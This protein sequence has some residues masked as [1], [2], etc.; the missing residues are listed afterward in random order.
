M[1]TPCTVAIYSSRIQTHTIRRKPI[2]TIP[3][4]YGILDLHFSPHHQD[5]FCTANST[6]SLSLFSTIQREH[7]DQ[8]PEVSVNLLGFYELFP[9]NTL[10]LACQWHPRH[11]ELIGVSL[12]NGN[13]VIVHVR[14][15]GSQSIELGDVKICASHELE[16]WTLAFTAFSSGDESENGILSGGD[17]SF[18][19]YVEE[20]SLK[21]SHPDQA[22]FHWKNRRIH[23]AGVTAIL[24]LASTLVLTGS[25]DD[26]V[27]LLNIPT[28]PKTLPRTLAEENID[29][30]VWR[31]KVIKPWSEI[32]NPETRR[33]KDADRDDFERL[34]LDICV[35][36]SCM[37]AGVR[38]LRV[39][40]SRS[41][42]ND[43]Q[44]SWTISVVARFEEHQSMNYGS[45][46]IFL[47]KESG[48]VD[49]KQDLYIVSTSFYDK[50]VCLTHVPSDIFTE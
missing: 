14:G 12:S 6:R 41:L 20:P 25:Y 3:T 11:P 29:G 44:S 2:L 16:A 31:L 42:V 9:E 46:F 32:Y 10:A 39:K 33:E 8:D 36:A 21:D 50:L 7:H 27:R 13:V 4:D 49:E 28:K 30:G 1:K 48:K 15:L 45:E 26:H 17:D 24:P 37:Y 22:A 34:E 47:P 40:G 35:L 19:Q 43:D 38:I 18:L 5:I 23:S